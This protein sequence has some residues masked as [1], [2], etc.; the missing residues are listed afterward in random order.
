MPRTAGVLNSENLAVP[1][2]QSRNGGYI[3][4]P[5]YFGAK[6]E[7]GRGDDAIWREALPEKTA[8]E[9]DFLPETG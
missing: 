9:R 6:P 8:E 7:D 3:P 4:L 5:H 1:C 2:R